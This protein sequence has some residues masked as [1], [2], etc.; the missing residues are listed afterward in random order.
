MFLNCA[1]PL[2]TDTFKKN[3]WAENPNTS[4]RKRG[5]SYFFFKL[6]VSKGREPCKK[7]KMKTHKSKPKG[8][9]KKK[10]QILRMP[11]SHKTGALFR[12]PHSSKLGHY[13]DA[14][15]PLNWAI[16]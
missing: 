6:P 5:P 4:V 11:T 10:E 16:V 15:I 3:W 8:L 12:C 7:L 9:L 1:G 14:H 2:L 13:L